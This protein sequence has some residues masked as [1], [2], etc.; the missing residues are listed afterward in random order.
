MNHIR[1][2][3]ISTGNIYVIL[4]MLGMQFSTVAS[5]EVKQLISWKEF[6]H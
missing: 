1:H 5:T 3:A 2:L 4:H 6:P